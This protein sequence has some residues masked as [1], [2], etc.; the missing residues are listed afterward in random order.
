MWCKMQRRRYTS[1]DSKASTAALHSLLG[2][3]LGASDLSAGLV[4]SLVLHSVVASASHIKLHLLP[5]M[6][7]L[8]LAPEVQAMRLSVVNAV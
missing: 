6:E 7:N 1:R 5:A 4:S 8:P 3:Y 2:M